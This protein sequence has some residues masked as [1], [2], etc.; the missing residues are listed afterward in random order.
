MIQKTSKI[1]L[2]ILLICGIGA[3]QIL[4]NPVTTN[5]AEKQKLNEI[6]WEYEDFLYEDNGKTITGF[7][8]QGDSKTFGSYILRIP[9]GVTKI[10][11]EAFK[12]EFFLEGVILSDTVIEIEEG[13]FADNFI[14]KL[15]L[16]KSLKKI[17]PK[18]FQ[19][20]TISSLTIPNS[21]QE[22]GEEAFDTNFIDTL[23]FE[24]K[25]KIGKNA[26]GS[27]YMEYTPEN[28]TFDAKEFKLLENI[29]NI[30]I[31]E[32]IEYKDGKYKI[33]SDEEDY[34]FEFNDAKIEY[35]GILI[36]NNPKYYF[37]GNQFAQA[38]NR[39]IRED[40]YYKKEAYDWYIFEI[41]N[42]TYEQMGESGLIVAGM[43]LAPYVKNN[44]TML[45]ISSLEEILDLDISYNN[46]IR[47]ATFKKGLTTLKIN[48]DTKT[49]TRNNKPYELEVKPEIKENRLCLPVSV[50]GKA[51]NKTLSSFNEKKN[52]DIVWNQETQEVVFY[53]YK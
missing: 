31:P 10:G 33:V 19:D 28:L 42:E 38:I 1:L 35:N 48:I 52:T 45:P 50:I 15:V 23:K 29:N 22:I 8:D 9:E 37:N 51:F 18:A 2:V 39:N 5:A 12:D 44:R 14:E 34:E 32:G 17:G 30:K 46:A 11:K 13:A 27:Q 4:V 16:G 53:K 49:A 41:G 21:V 25:P 47:T 6:Q 43:N 20:N 36:I 26:F 7:S 24:S 3:T 40:K